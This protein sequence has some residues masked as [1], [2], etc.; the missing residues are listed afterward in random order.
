MGGTSSN[1]HTQMARFVTKRSTCAMQE[2][3]STW[4]G[5]VM[6]GRVYNQIHVINK[7]L[8]KPV[9]LWELFIFGSSLDRCLH[10]RVEDDWSRSSS[11]LSH[12]FIQNLE[13][14]RECLVSTQTSCARSCHSRLGVI[15]LTNI[16]TGISF[17]SSDGSGLSYVFKLSSERAPSNNDCT[18]CWLR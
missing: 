15:V 1:K 5:E 3:T 6:I 14:F 7:M 18:A 2:H 16:K 10:T 8:W 12:T 11:T 17:H 9:Q 4:G 13:L